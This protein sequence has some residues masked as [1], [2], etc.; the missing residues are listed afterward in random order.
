M[1]GTT[2]TTPLPAAALPPEREPLDAQAVDRWVWTFV[3]VG[4]AA[5]VLRYLLCFPLWDDEC[6][7]MTNFIDRGYGELLQPLDYHQVAPLLFLWTE[8][9]LI[10]L[11]GYNE[12]AMRLLGFAGG[13]ASLFVFRHLARRLFSGA[14]LVA[15]VGVFAVAYPCIRYSAEAKP[16]GSD[17]LIG[18]VLMT[19]AVEWRRRPEQSRWIWSMAAAM[20]LFVGLSY[21]AVFI[22]GAL[23]L[24][25]LPTLWAIRSVRGWAAWCVYNFAML[26]S[27]VGFFLVATQA[28]SSAELGFM[29]DFWKKTFPPLNEPWKVPLWLIEVHTGPWLGYPIGGPNG[30]STLSFIYVL[31]TIVVW[32]RTKRRD[33]LALCLLPLALNLVAAALHRYPYGG[34]AKL[35]H[36]AAAPI[37]LMIGFGL[38][39]A[40]TWV[41]R[42]RDVSLLP[43]FRGAMI[44]MA[45]IGAGCMFRD[46]VLPQKTLSDTRHRDFA[47]WFWFN[48]GFE[49]ET[50][51]VM[52]D[53]KQTFSP[54]AM[55]ELNWTA[56]YLCNQKIYSP[57][58]HRNEA[59]HWDRV[60]DEHPLR[61]VLF[62]TQLTPFDQAA[63][64]RWLDE[65]QTK[66]DLAGEETL[67]FSYFLKNERTLAVMD[68]LKIYRFVPKTENRAE[69]ARLYTERR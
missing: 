4:L 18:L 24:W 30:A 33:L 1:H 32:W 69:T 27:F 61:C 38:A 7:L 28:Q 37:C 41:V 54:A 16:Y 55:K 52:S 59:V 9:L 5:R 3:A 45:L 25:M 67:P 22:G 43:L 42:R 46:L 66:Y 34:H 26:A 19:L 49:G 57:R 47:R 62:A 63:E 64:R 23:S 50:C 10:D 12:Y 68:H 17:M 15:A 31:T 20:P 60:S 21:P 8:R 13:V 6:F 53:L 58:H 65:M 11:F 36:Y 56:M 40:L 29:T 51:C 44:V 48:A 14:A 35:V 2:I 39:A